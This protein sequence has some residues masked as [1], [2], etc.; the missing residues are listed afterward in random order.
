MK[1]KLVEF[2]KEI[3]EKRKIVIGLKIIKEVIS[4][5]DMGENS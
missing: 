1:S 2:R 5:I 3:E 4:R